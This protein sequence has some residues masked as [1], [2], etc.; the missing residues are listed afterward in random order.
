MKRKT[1]G[2]AGICA[3]AVFLAGLLWLHSPFRH[4]GKIDASLF[5]TD[6]VEGLVRNLLRED[7]LR[8]TQVCFLGFGEGGTSPGAGFIARFADCRHPAVLALNSTVAPPGNRVL[9]KNN[10]HAGTVVKI[11]VFRELFPGDYDV[12]VALSCLPAGHDHVVYH[13]TSVAGDWQATKRP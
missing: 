9:E 11:I 12:T 3:A 6:M 5:E 8:D 13:V 10:G 7:G 1:L 2:G 4:P